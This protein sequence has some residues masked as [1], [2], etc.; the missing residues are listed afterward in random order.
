MNSIFSFLVPP[1]QHTFIYVYINTHTRYFFLAAEDCDD[2]GI[3][4][5]AQRTASQF[6]FGE[7]VTYMC[8]VGLD[9]LGSSERVC[10]ESREWS[11]SP[12]RCLGAVPLAVF[13]F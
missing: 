13:F 9:L 11:G 7:K 3:P 6:H 4:P 5:G 2:P 12:P 1:Q 10:L 8:H